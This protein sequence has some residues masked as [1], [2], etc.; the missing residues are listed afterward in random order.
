MILG[1]GVDEEHC[2][3]PEEV[4]EKLT[5]CDTARGPCMTDHFQG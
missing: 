2:N 3:A 1:T 4:N 5:D